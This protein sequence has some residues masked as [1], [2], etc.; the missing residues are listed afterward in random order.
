M[1]WGKPEYKTMDE[2][3]QAHFKKPAIGSEHIA[4]EILKD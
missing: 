3:G 4:K 1:T 2:T